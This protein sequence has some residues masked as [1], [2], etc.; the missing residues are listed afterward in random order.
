MA[1]RQLSNLDA[2]ALGFVGVISRER[3]I[4][5][6]EAFDFA[7]W[8][9]NIAARVRV[10]AEPRKP[11]ATKPTGRLNVSRAEWNGMTLQQR[12]D[13]SRRAEGRA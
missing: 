5:A 4:G 13:R 10:T 9:A 6:S 7:G 2:K 12:L 11:S 8:G 3:A 1:H